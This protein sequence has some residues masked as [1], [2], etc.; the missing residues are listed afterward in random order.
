M[1]ESMQDFCDEEQQA[2]SSNS[3]GCVS[4][5]TFNILAPI[6]KRLN[7][8]NC[9]SEFRELWLSRN[10]SILDRLL[11]LSSS[12]ICLQEFWVHNE[13][14]VTMYEKRLGDA[15]YVTYKL[16]RTNNRG[17]GLL[18][19]VHQNH[20]H[21]LNYQECLFNDIGDRVAQLLHVEL[22]VHFSENQLTNT[23]KEVLVMNTHLIFPHDSSYCFV[24]LKQVYK[25]LKYIDSYCHENE[26]PPVPVILCGD[27]N[28]SKKGNVYK[29]L[30]SQGF[31]SSYDIAHPYTNDAEDLSKWISHHNH[32]G[33]VCGVDFI[34]LHNPSNYQRPVKE[35]FM[36][37]VLGNINDL[38]HKLSTKGVGPL[39]FFET[40]SSH[41]TYSQ[42]SHALAEVFPSSYL[43]NLPN[44]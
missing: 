28:G 43:K 16:A 9:E 7:G 44:F 5:T 38:S 26:L 39:H 35:S 14:L 23:R 40:D 31:V 1:G 17:D 19:A 24:R 34:F 30:Q 21:V 6:Y 8:Q 25:M 12:I 42:F 33:N 11:T 36:E 13:E 22:L 2:P 15:G 18:T 4:C 10:E 32:R 29:F 27:W 37:A 20:F 41:I 3:V